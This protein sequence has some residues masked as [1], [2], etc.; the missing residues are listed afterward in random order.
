MWSRGHRRQAVNGFQHG[1]WKG[2]THIGVELSYTRLVRRRS[3]LGCMVN[4][5]L[6]EEFIEYVEVPFA[7]DLFGVAAHNSLRR[8][9]PQ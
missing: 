4:E 2:T 5:I 3:S 1:I 8:I 6:G 9:G 7:L